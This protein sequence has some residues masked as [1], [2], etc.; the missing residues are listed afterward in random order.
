[1]AYVSQSWE[2]FTIKGST[3]LSHLRSVKVIY[4]STD[5]GGGAYG[6]KMKCMSVMSK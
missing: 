4:A 1:M 2:L 5:T 3:R 6:E